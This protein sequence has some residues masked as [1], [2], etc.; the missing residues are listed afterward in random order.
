MVQYLEQIRPNIS[1]AWRADELYL[2]VKGNPKIFVRPHGYLDTILD[3]TARHR[4]KYT[5]ASNF[6][7]QGSFHL[8]IQQNSLNK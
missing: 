7:L 1:D 8:S 4:H 3:R 2:R 6:E 5:S